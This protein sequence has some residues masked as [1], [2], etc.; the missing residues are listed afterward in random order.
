MGPT[1]RQGVRGGTQLELVVAA[2]S[3]RRVLTLSGLDR[4][5]TVYPFPTAAIAAASPAARV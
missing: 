1:C 3:V 2:P 4:L 5:I